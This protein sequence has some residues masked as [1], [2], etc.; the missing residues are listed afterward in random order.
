MTMERTRNRRRNSMTAFK[1]RPVA[2]E[3]LQSLL[4][5]NFSRVCLFPLENDQLTFNQMSLHI[6]VH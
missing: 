5:S 2:L 1:A 4:L 3:L 6:S